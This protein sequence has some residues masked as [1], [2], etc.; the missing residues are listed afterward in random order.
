MHRRTFLT[1]GGRVVA[2]LAISGCL[3]RASSRS[4]PLARRRVDLVP[5]DVS[6]DRI[7]RTTVG[8][9]PHRDSGFVVR[10]DRFDEKTV[11][12]NYGHGGAGYSLSWGTGALVA[13]LALGHTE[14][15]AAVIGCG[16]VGL[17]AARQLQRRGFDVTIYAASLP[18]ETT[19][20][21][22]WAAFTPVSGLISAER[23]TPEWDDQF[24]RAVEI[25]YRQ[26]QLLAGPRYGV[27]WIDDYSPIADPSAPRRRSAVS[28]DESGPGLLG[29]ATTLGR[30]MLGPGEHPFT[31]PYASHTPSL[32][33]EPSIYLDAVMR[34]VIE[35]G[36]RIVVRAFDTPR[37]LMSLSESLL[38]NCTGLGAK[39]L[40]DDE[41][42]VPVKGQLTVL[43]PQADVTYSAGGMMP[44]SDGIVLGHVS[45]RGVWSLDVDEGERKR[46]VDGAIAFFG[47]MRSPSGVVAGASAS[48]EAAP[49]ISPPPVESF[50]DRQS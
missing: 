27:S 3:P 45:Q 37:D 43:V 38:V 23:R 6:W 11:I 33:F 16:I 29:P 2:G 13:D 15:R 1:T 25:A 8:L 20:N 19:S 22:A 9:R 18:P 30:V 44:R 48:S 39:T 46:V 26:H 4:V 14:R 5:V 12:H 47:R 42:L 28:G 50:F 7:I 41:E 49:A 31:T 34:D 21:M 35:F 24:R 10:A 17:T 36:G 40:F 32:R